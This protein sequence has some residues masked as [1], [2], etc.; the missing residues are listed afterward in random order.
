VISDSILRTTPAA[1]RQAVQDFFTAEV[2]GRGRLS[3]WVPGEVT[4]VFAENYRAL[5]AAVR[6]HGR[7]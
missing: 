2:K 6:E 5:Y 4:G 1:I 3:L 7:Y